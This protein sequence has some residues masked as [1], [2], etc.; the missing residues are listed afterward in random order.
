MACTDAIAK[1]V[2][3]LIKDKGLKKRYVAEK[4]GFTA[5]DFSRM[6]NGKK[7]I[8]AEYIPAIA[9]ALGVTPNDIYG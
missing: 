7:I 2:C 4:A 8:R 5:A 6:I 3:R 9:H 1:N